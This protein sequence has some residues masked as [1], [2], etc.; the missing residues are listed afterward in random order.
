MFYKELDSIKASEDEAESIVRE[1]QERS[2][3]IIAEGKK[4]AE[5]AILK[6]EREAIE[7]KRSAATE[8]KA[9]AKYN[10]DNSIDAA[11]KK[12]REM[13]A[14]AKKNMKKAAEVIA[15]RIVKKSVDS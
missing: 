13:E 14:E 8:G 6:A 9:I 5:E 7:A 10:Y 11:N 2:K 1:A 15:E 3:E 12:A 4:K